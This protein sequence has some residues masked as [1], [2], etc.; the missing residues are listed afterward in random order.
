MSLTQ[1]LRQEVLTA[2]TN[3]QFDKANLDA[4]TMAR[5]EYHARRALHLERIATVRRIITGLRQSSG[6]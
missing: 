6:S 3:M 1:I 5:S 4:G 2:K